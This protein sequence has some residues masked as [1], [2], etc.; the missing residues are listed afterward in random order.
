MMMMIMIEEDG[1]DRTGPTRQNSIGL[2]PKYQILTQ[3]LHS[4]SPFRTSS[5]NV[6]PRPT[7]H[8]PCH[9]A[10]GCKPDHLHDLTPDA[11]RQ[12]DR[13]MQRAKMNSCSVG[14]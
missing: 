14:R 1:L 6:V 12:T 11:D 10:A 2:D 3:H 7:I 5:S 4:L 9:L 13:Q 8:S